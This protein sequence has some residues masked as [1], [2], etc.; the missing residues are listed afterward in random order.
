MARDKI[1]KVELTNMCMIVDNKKQKL[2]VEERTRNDW[3]GLTFPGGHV[4][5]G[6]S[7]LESVV[8]EIKEETGLTVSNLI[9][10]GIRE[11]PSF[12]PGVRYLSFLYKTSDFTGNLKSSDEGKVKWLSISE[13]KAGPMAMD[14]PELLE[15]FLA[16]PGGNYY[17]NKPNYRLDSKVKEIADL[18]LKKSIYLSLNLDSA[19][20]VA[21]SSLFVY[22]ENNTYLAYLVLSQSSKVALEIKLYQALSETLA[23]TLIKAAINYAISNN[24]S[25]L[26][27]SVEANQLD[28]IALYETL[29]F[30]VIKTTATIVELILSF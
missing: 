16:S 28:L 9:L 25:Y 24:Y 10:C 4:E 26:L 18:E 27:T 17:F 21:A 8:R 19:M 7:V 20:N 11:W 15:E 2:L 1:S 23:K 3:P 22:Q 14:F 5:T 30:K 13:I 29:G 6:E 12:E